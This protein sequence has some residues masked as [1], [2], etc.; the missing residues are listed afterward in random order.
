MSLGNGPCSLASI[1]SYNKFP[2]IFE[3][4]GPIETR[5][6]YFCNSLVWAKVST[7]GQSTTMV[8]HTLNFILWQAS[9][10]YPIST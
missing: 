8:E 6:E 1:T 9:S 2:C 4:S 5:L 3:A 7:I 10:V